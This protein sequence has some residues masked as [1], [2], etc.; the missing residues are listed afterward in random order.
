VR[1][2]RKMWAKRGPRIKR[3]VSRQDKGTKKKGVG[4]RVLGFG[5]GIKKTLKEG[6]V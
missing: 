4:E 2:K 1:E 5:G 6:Q 3:K